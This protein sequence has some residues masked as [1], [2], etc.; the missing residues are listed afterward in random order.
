[1]TTPAVERMGKRSSV[2]IAESTDGRGGS[3]HFHDH[4]V[5]GSELTV[6]DP[7]NGCPLVVEP[8]RYVFVVGGIGITSLLPMVEALAEH[9]KVWRL[10][11]GGH[12]RALL[13]FIERLAEH[14]HRVHICPED[15]SGLL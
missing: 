8:R 14:G 4:A 3:I 13:P 7:R 9:D 6:R 12:T 5:S 1:M 10:R 2:G 15:E 11:Y